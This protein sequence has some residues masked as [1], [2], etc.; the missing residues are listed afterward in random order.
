MRESNLHAVD[1]AISGTLQDSEVVVINWIGDN[2]V[3]KSQRHDSC[4]GSRET[5]GDN[6]MH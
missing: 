6:H 1:K 5:D 3:D 4:A 2:V